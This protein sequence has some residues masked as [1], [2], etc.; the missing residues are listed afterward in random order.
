MTATLIQD[1]LPGYKGHAALFKLSPPM[2]GHPDW[3]DNG[4]KIAFRNK[5]LV[6]LEDLGRDCKGHI[7][8]T[9]AVKNWNWREV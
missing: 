2:E 9:D 5:S 3:D 4:N 8:S 6:V 1:N 7:V